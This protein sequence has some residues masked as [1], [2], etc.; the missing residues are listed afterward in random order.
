[1]M[2]P[3]QLWKL[4]M[5]TEEL[6]DQGWA[7]GKLIEKVV[8]HLTYAALLARELLSCF[9]AVYVFIK[10][11]YAAK[12]RLWPRVRRELF[13]AKR[14]LPSV[15][16]DLGAEWSPEVFAN[17]CLDFASQRANLAGWGEKR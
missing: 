15:S 14:L 16:R 4:K 9:E 7:S 10:K 6:L 11:H 5:G 2:T 13:W 17:Q 1:M 3:R 8:G 12:A